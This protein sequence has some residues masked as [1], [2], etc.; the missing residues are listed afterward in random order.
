[1]PIPKSVHGVRNLNLVVSSF[2]TITLGCL[3]AA[4]LGLGI[5]VAGSVQGAEPVASDTD[6]ALVPVA[7]ATTDASGGEYDG[8]DPVNP[9]ILD[10]QTGTPSADKAATARSRPIDQRDVIFSN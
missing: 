7:L 10:A 2:A 5:A 9:E 1:V 4:T 8:L 6:A 3:F